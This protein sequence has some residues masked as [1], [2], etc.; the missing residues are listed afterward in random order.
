MATQDHL[1]L[2]EKDCPYS[3]VYTA[4]VSTT[5]RMALV[6]SDPPILIISLWIR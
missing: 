2:N 5:Y 6:K 3:G 1:V 4:E